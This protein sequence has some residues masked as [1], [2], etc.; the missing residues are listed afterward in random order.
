MGTHFDYTSDALA[1]RCQEIQ[2]AARPGSRALNAMRKDMARI[3]VDDHREMMLRGVDGRGRERA[4]LADSTQED[5]RRGPGPSL[6]PNR[7]RSRFYRNVETLWQT[8]GGVMVLVKRL[9]NIV[10]K[11]GRSIIEYHLNG[12]TKRGSRW[13]LPKRDVRGI[14]PRGWARLRERQ[15]QFV[16]DLVRSGGGR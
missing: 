5:R 11:K 6:I 3:V 4:Q 16:Q 10:D 1:R 9:F 15:R 14:T 2:E 13:R 7:E 12:A 8:V